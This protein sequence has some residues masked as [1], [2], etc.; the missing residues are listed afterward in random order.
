MTRRTSQRIAALVVAGAAILPSP[1]AVAQDAPQLA[2]PVA[3]QLG[4]TCFIQHY[5]DVDGSSGVSDHACGAA[6]YDGHNGIDFRLL[7]A[8][9]ARSG[10][11]VLAAADGTVLRVRDGVVDAFA[12]EGGRAAIGDRECGNGVIIQH[13]GGVETQY[14]HLLQ[15]SVAVRPGQAVRTGD[16]LGRVGYSGLADFAHLHF[17]VRRDGREVDPYTGLGTGKSAADAGACRTADATR[18]LWSAAMVRDGAYR[19]ADIIQ[20]GFSEVIPQWQAL[21]RDHGAVPEVRSDSGQLVFYVR[22]IKLLAGDQIR[23]AINGPG[24]FRVAHTTPP[25]ERAQAIRVVGAGKRLTAARWAAGRYEA[26][27]EVLR[28]GAAVATARGTLVLP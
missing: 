14:C 21:E 13:A 12:R 4:Q 20:A 27:A 1:G 3:C 5:V 8:V 26:E 24:G 6:T 18:G 23:I 22:A 2:L 10:V 7:S 11:G 19:P 25:L 16:V 9:Q 28:G 17:V 15:G